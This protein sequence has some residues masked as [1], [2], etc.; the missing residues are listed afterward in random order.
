MNTPPPASN[1]SQSAPASASFE[2]AKKNALTIREKKEKYRAE[3]SRKGKELSDMLIDPNVLILADWLKVRSTLKNWPKFWCVLKPGALIL[4][5]TE[6][7]EQ[8]GNWC[9]TVL[10]SYCEVMERPS[11]KEG[12]CF[13]IYHP[14]EQ[15]IWASRG[16]RGESLRAWTQPLPITHLI[17][18]TSS[19]AAGRTWIDGID[20]VRKCQPELLIKSISHGAKSTDT[21]E[22]SSLTPP[23]LRVQ[24]VD[25]HLG[26]SL[27]IE[28]AKRSTS[29]NSV[30]D[31]D[32]KKAGI[33]QDDRWFDAS[34]GDDVSKMEHEIESTEEWQN[35]SDATDDLDGNEMFRNDEESDEEMG[36]DQKNLRGRYSTVGVRG[37]RI[38]RGFRSTRRSR[39]NRRGR[40]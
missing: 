29:I 27:N 24:L 7:T 40:R 17:L 34:T 35:S 11:K 33:D 22:A 6:K 1:T 21:P 4:Y 30:G 38:G 23:S 15:T 14:L 31:E 8:A 26:D 32:N 37:A 2:A 19:E 25:P 5:K 10:L 13:K 12:F 20:L 3:K 28:Y 16:P 36:E 18:R 39:A 9:G